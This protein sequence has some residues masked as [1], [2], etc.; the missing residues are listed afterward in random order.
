MK[1]FNILRHRN[2]YWSCSTLANW[3]LSKAG[4]KK[5]A[6]GTE[7]DWMDWRKVTPWNTVIEDWFDNLQDIFTFPYDVCD[8]I[9]IYTRNRFITKTHMIDTKLTPGLW[10]ESDERLLHGMFNVL[11][12]F[13][14]VEKAH[15][16]NVCETS[17]EKPW[18]LRFRFLRWGEHRSIESGIAYL[19][20][21]ID[22]KNKRCEDYDGLDMTPQSISAQEQKDLY[23]WWRNV[24]PNRE[25]IHEITGY[26]K[27]CEEIYPTGWNVFQDLTPEQNIK[28]ELVLNNIYQIETTR[29]QEDEDMMI[30]LIKLRQHLWT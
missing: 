8:T 16:N 20:W 10:H 15:M 24:R 14:E 2:N 19:D 27:L 26:T 7:E 23:L 25:D 21:E 17:Q 5:P 4:T 30:R 9:R 1:S 13:V 18:W 11:V 3:V 29:E 22:L 28:M 12:D 6:V